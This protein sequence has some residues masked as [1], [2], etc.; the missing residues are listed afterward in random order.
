MPVVWQ[1]STLKVTRDSSLALARGSHR[2]A[3]A[4][5]TCEVTVGYSQ[6]EAAI[7]RVQALLD[8]MV[9]TDTDLSWPTKDAHMLGY[10]LR[11]AMT[12]AK[13]IGKSPYDTLKDKFTIRNRGDRVV[14]E[15]K[16]KE[17]IEALQSLMSKVELSDVT[18]TVEIVGAA[19]V[20]SQA[21]ELYFP[22]AVLTDEDKLALWKW[23]S[24]NEYYIIVAE[25]GV[26]LTKKDPGEVAWTPE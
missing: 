26:T 3:Q 16:V 13:R 17:G 11:E 9:V 19:I 6:N 21:T 24:K 2:T 1:D 25:I 7:N 5:K 20:H 10:H 14:A 12:L 8:Q 18:S 22:D 23:S 15:L 4:R